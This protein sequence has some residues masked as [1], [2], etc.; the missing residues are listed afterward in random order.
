MVASLLVV[1]A[2]RAH[3]CSPGSKILDDRCKVWIATILNA[4]HS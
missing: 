1:V 3:V 4:E 2:N